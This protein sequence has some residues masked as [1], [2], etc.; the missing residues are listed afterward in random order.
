[1]S[2]YY[3]DGAWEARSRVWRQHRDYLS[4]LHYFL[5]TDPRVPAAF[6]EETAALGLDQ[7]MHPDTEG[8]PN[9]LYV[10][11]TRRMRGPYVLTLADVWNETKVEDGV[12]LALYGV[13]IYPVRRYAVASKTGSMRADA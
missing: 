6:R 8:W 2:R 3:Q 12:G 5:S 4:G 10:R 11:L 9:Q 1:M 13:D 7:T